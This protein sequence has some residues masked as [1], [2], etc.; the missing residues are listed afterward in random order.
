MNQIFNTPGLP[1]GIYRDLPEILKESAEL[2]R[3]PVEKDVFLVSSIAVISG[4]LP[5]MEGI[6][7]D[8]PVSPHLYLFITA[9]AGSGKGKMKWSR[10]FGQTIHEELIGHA[11]ADRADYLERLEYYLNLER[12]NRLNESKPAEP[13]RRM[14]FIPA[15]SSSSAFIQALADNGFRGVIFETEADTLANT[16]RQEWGNFSDV[17]RKAF[18]HESTSLFRRKD[19]EFIEIEDPHLAIA[20]SG[21]PRQVHHMM[22]DAENGLF[23]RFLYYAFQDNSCFRNP[24]VSNQKIDYI[25]FFKEQGRK[26]FELNHRLT[27]LKRPIT[28][29]LTSDQGEHFTKVFDDMLNRN[30]LL[31]GDDFEA[32]TKRLG[33]ITFRIAMILSALHLI[34]NRKIP[35]KVVCNDPDYGTALSIATTLE[36]H[37]IAVYRNLP[38]NRLTGIKQKLYEA[39]PDTFNR[40]IYLKTAEEL[41]IKEKNADKYIEQLKVRLLKYENHEYSETAVD[42]L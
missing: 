10:Y 29:S 35:E 25:R 33:L 21:T 7:F 15:N 4:C 6:Y 40:K 8:E 2:F 31:L 20:L 42:N 32:N 36:K 39:L 37:A 38:G 17:L 1:E 26:I 11:K 13:L 28:F 14:L 27:F 23:S 12:R 41:G 34:D 18:H 5:N 24:F 30:K 16:F 9:P 22:P 19:D 3:E